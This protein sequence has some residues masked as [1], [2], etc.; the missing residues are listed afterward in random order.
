MKIMIMM[1]D[2]FID[3]LIMGVQHVQ[4]GVQHPVNSCAT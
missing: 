4:T 3:D 1:L 2:T